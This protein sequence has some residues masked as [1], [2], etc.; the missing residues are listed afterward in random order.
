VPIVAKIILAPWNLKVAWLLYLFF[1]YVL[2]EHKKFNGHPVRAF[3]NLQRQAECCMII[4]ICL[5]QWLPLAPL[6]FLLLLRGR[7]VTVDRLQFGF[8]FFLLYRYDMVQIVL[9]TLSIMAS[10]QD[11]DEGLSDTPEKWHRACQR[12]L[13]FRSV[14]VLTLMLAYET[15][16]TRSVL[17]VAFAG[18]KLVIWLYTV[19][20]MPDKIEAVDG[21]PVKML[22]G[23]SHRI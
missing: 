20:D 13:M 19:E 2:L 9:V 23:K 7:H 17:L 10:L 6:P 21:D 3:H 4:G 8:V 16:Y 22:Q 1:T 5:S 15:W 11:V 14:Q 18:L 12:R